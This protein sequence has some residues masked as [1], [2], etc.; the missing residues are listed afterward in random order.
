MRRATSTIVVFYLIFSAALTMLETI[1]WFDAMGMGG[2]IS[3]G[4]K[5]QEASMA[6]TQL[7]ASGGFT[8]TLIALYVGATSTFQGF[9]LGV[10][11]GPQLLINMG[12]PLSIV[13]FIHSPLIVLVGLDGLYILTGRDA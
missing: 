6:A 2:S 13:G 1:G 7:S 12:V 5:L 9:A 11:A 10:F 4:T 3:A 8:D